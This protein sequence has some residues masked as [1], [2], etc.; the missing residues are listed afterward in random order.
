MKGARKTK[1]SRE[2]IAGK[3]LSKIYQTASH[4]M[5]GARHEVS[6]V[7]EVDISLAQQEIHGLVGE[8]GCGKTTLG[9]V[10]VG[11]ELATSGQVYFKGNLV[12]WDQD[13]SRRLRGQMG[14]VFQDPSAS[15]NPRLT[16]GSAVG[17]PLLLH[18]RATGRTLSGKVDEL[19]ASVGLSPHDATRYPHEFSGGQRQRVGLA[20]ALAS[21]PEFLVCDE[22]TS[23][24]D[25]SVAAG[26]LNLL[27]R[28]QEEKKLSYLF[29]SHD[30]RAVAY[31]SGKIAVM[32]A[33]EIVEEGKRSEVYNCPH[34]P[35]TIGL[36][37]ALPRIGEPKRPVRGRRKVFREGKQESVGKGC[38]YR[39]RCSRARKKCAEDSPV[40]RKV[41]TGHRSA[42]FFD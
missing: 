28:M 30:L 34:H 19:L 9:K 16:I 14:F 42:C 32:Y 4:P 6:A 10:L 12:P 8:S 23:S 3:G 22:P 13:S 41:G 29:I 40:L 1:L 27:L 24:L 33:G 38:S 5:G 11:L 26:V 7:R 35:Y 20:R 31:L 21:G 17:E 25:L 37:A 36:L 15:L 18:G 2:I 39:D